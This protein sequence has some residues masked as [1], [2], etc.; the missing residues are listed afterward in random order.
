[1][2][3][4]NEAIKTGKGKLPSPT[5]TIFKSLKLIFFNEQA[6]L[7]LMLNRKHTFNVL[8]M[9]GVSLVVPFKGLNGEIHPENF[10]N[11]VE[12]VLLTFIF[13]GLIYLY[14]PKKKGVFLA[15]TR[16]ILSFEAMSVFLPVTFLLTPE[17]LRYF[18]P[19][20]LAWYLSLSIFAV[21]KIKGYGYFLSGIVVFAA[22][23]VTIL[24]PA[25]F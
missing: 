2:R 11:I 1:M 24:F 6:L 9:Y 21:S 5:N 15:T 13:I 3:A 23:I 4:G 19:M 8:F 25:F 22:F 10:G 16:V 17:Q 7:A 18:H 12:S 20:F 14:L